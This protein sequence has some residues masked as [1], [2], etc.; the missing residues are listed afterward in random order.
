MLAVRQA[1]LVSWRCNGCNAHVM[2]A[3]R[4][5]HVSAGAGIRV[6]I[7]R[8]NGCNAHGACSGWT[9]KDSTHLF[10]LRECRRRRKGQLLAV[11]GEERTIR[12]LVGPAGAGSGI[13][14][15]CKTEADWC[16]CR[17]ETLD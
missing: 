11:T 14:P 15:G 16:G 2:L 8:C 10:A 1:S 4:Q 3:W 5:A 13:K 17:H 7:W 9:R 12:E 6:V